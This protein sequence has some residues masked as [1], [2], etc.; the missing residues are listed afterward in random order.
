MRISR[1]W[2]T[3]MAPMIRNRCYWRSCNNL[4]LSL[5]IWMKKKKETRKLSIYSWR[6]M[7]NFGEIYSLNMLIQDIIPNK[8]TTLI[9]WTRNIKLWAWQKWPSFLKIMLHILNSLT[10]KNFNNYSDLLTLRLL[11]EMTYKHLNTTVTNNSC[12]N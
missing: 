12:H 4:R 1:H 11:I 10:K 7:L 9:N 8:L 3:R 2:Y 6:S 5:L